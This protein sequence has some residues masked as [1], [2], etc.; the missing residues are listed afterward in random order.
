MRCPSML[1]D[2]SVAGTLKQWEELGLLLVLLGAVPLLLMTA[3]ARNEVPLSPMD[4]PP[5]GE[6]GPT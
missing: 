1:R 2:G 4:G 3:T 6:T 5:F